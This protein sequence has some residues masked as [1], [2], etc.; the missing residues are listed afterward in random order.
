[1]AFRPLKKVETKDLKRGII[2][3]SAVITVGGAIVFGTGAS[4]AFVVA[5][6]SSSAL[7]VGTV[8]GIEGLNGKVLELNSKTVASDNQTVAQIAAVYIPTYIP[9]EYEADTSAAT[10]TTTGSAGVG[11]FN[12]TDA[13]TL[14]ESTW[15][16]FSGTA[17]QFAS[18]GVTPYNTSKVY[19]QFYKAF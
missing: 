15:V 1:M 17:G 7:I 3:N 14:N 19:G 10:G 2:S 12:L 18:Y 9:M 4:S 6:T 5:A 13:N 16:A 8:V 11:F